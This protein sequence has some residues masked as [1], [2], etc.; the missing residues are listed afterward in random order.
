MIFDTL[1]NATRYM[2]L[3][4]H[5]AK[6]LA[7]IGAYADKPTGKHV[8]D[9]SDLFVLVQEYTTKELADSMWEAHHAYADIH[10]VISGKETIGYASDATALRATSPYDSA[11]DAE[12]LEGI[13]DFITCAPGTFALL[14]PYEPHMPCVAVDSPE[15]VKKIVIKIKME[16]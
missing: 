12:L 7:A 16:A 11:G 10:C 2:G 6:G 14:F 3:S 9:G 13:G 15:N 4:P 1:T 5:I 8:I